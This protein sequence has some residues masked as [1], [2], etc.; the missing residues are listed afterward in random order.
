M[1]F[2][3]LGYVALGGFFV[4]AMCVAAARGDRG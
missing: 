1:E 2:I 4:I 3:I